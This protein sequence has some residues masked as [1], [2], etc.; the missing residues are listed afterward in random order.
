MIADP[1]PDSLD[2]DDPQH[3]ALTVTDDDAIRAVNDVVEGLQTFPLKITLPDGGSINIM[4][5]VSTLVTVASAGRMGSDGWGRWVTVMIKLNS[6][7]NLPPVS[8]N[9]SLQE[10]RQVVYDSP[11]AQFCTCFTFEFEGKRLND[12]IELSQI[13]G[14]TPESVVNVKEDAYNEREVR[15]HIARMREVITN[16]QVPTASYG[17]DQAISFLPTIT[18]DPAQLM[19]GIDSTFEADGAKLKTHDANGR[20]IFDGPKKE[21]KSAA[22]ATSDS[23][24]DY[25]VEERASTPLSSFVPEE[26]SS[27]ARETC[28][29][30]F[31]LSV[32]NPPPF[33]RRLAGDLMYLTVTTL[34]K[35]TYHITCSVSG[36][37]ANQSNGRDFDPTPRP[38][39]CLHHS[40]PGMLALLSPL[41]AT[42]FARLQDYIHKRHP[43]EY[44]ATNTPALPWLVRP[45]THTA[46]PGRTLDIQLGALD[47][48]DSFGGRDWNDDLQAARELPRS[49]PQERVL[50]DATVAKAHADFVDA[51]VRGVQSV[52]AGA[53]AALNPEDPAPSQMYL[54]NNIFF[55]QGYDQREQFERFGGRDAAHVAISKDVDGVRALAALDIEGLHL[56][57]TAV[58]DFLGHRI[59]A[60]SIIPGILKSASDSAVKYGSVEHGQ[61]VK[62]DSDF[63]ELA[64]KVAAKLKIAEHKVVDDQGKVSTLHMSVETKGILGT[65]GRRYLLDLYRITPIDIAFREEVEK[66]LENPYPHQMVLFRPELVE[67][68]SEI[69]LLDFVDQKR[70]ERQ[71][72]AAE[73]KSAG[74]ESGATEVVPSESAEVAEESTPV[75]VDDEE[76]LLPPPNMLFNP[77]L[78]TPVGNGATEDEIAQE[79]QNVREL[80]A[81]LHDNVIPRMVSFF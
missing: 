3:L 63:H 12:Q 46:D 28:F 76:L 35:D 18:Q 19:A 14:F 64:G 60:Q 57:G 2:R 22:T 67:G 42:H 71:A 72:A 27:E 62:F 31:G 78:L 41:F 21:S 7:I 36:F 53:V 65:D 59:A 6:S 80:S 33:Q 23:F 4:A 26:F 54:H 79:V 58:I 52:I 13:E 5:S 75:E 34:E 29:R 9:T 37:F 44:I 17:V 20:R 56:L 73:K 38:K 25:V 16:F 74:A 51:A 69:R 66:D 24:E 61:E 10:I 45:R 8:P 77:D 1:T 68:F 30:Q 47:A 39:S 70:R 48:V 11:A 81:Y 40:L 50:R 49:T 55:S 15:I 43:Y 32:W